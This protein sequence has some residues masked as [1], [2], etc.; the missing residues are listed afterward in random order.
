MI[1]KFLIIV[2][3]YQSGFVPFFDFALLIC[4]DSSYIATRIFWIRY[5]VKPMQHADIE[6]TM[7]MIEIII[8]HTEVV[9]NDEDDAYFT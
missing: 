5:K 8:N 9:F 2:Q 6:I 7:A 3:F 4:L 1:C